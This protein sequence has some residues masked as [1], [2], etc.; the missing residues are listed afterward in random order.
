MDTDKL[1]AAIF[2]AQLSLGTS[3]DAI[4]DDYEIFLKK[5]RQRALK[6]PKLY[7]ENLTK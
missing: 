3:H 4:L 5:M 2:A 7:P 1:I 6:E